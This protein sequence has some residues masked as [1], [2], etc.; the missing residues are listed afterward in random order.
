[1]KKAGEK[2][3]KKHAKNRQKII[4]HRQKKNVNVG[5]KAPYLSA[6]HAKKTGGAQAAQPFVYDYNCLHLST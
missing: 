1:M 3:R 6:K 5:K 4:L 2:Q